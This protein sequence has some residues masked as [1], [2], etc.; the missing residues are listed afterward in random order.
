MFVASLL[1]FLFTGNIAVFPFQLLIKTKKKDFANLSVN[2]FLEFK[3]KV[4]R[5]VSNLLSGSV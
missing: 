4:L 2:V 1:H 5:F 3:I